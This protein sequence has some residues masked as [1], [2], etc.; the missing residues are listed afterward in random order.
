MRA[1]SAQSPNC[2]CYAERFARTIRAE[3][4]THFVIFG[5]RHL[6]YLVQQFIEHY[7]AERYHQGIGGQLI[8]P[9][10]GPSNDNARLGT[11]DAGRVSAECSTS[12]IERRRE[13]SRR[14]FG[15]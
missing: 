14:V 13:G 15:H 3:C 5:E 4:L 12:N 6:R 11:L 10:P 9:R 8:Q 1:H 2:N 7:Q